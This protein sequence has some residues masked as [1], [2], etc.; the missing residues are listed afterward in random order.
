[1]QQ[2]QYQVVI[3]P[4][5]SLQVPL[6]LPNHGA[7]VITVSAADT[8]GSNAVFTVTKPEDDTASVG[9]ITVNSGRHGEYLD[10]TWKRQEEPALHL[11]SLRDD[12]DAKV[13][14]NVLDEFVYEVKWF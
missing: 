14:S 8:K 10:F 4:N 5:E 3:R 11:K 13:M 7:F 1:M 2:Q 9:R 6:S 12:W